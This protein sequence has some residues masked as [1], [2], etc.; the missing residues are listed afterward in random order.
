MNNT[1]PVILQKLCRQP[2]CAAQFI[3]AKVRLDFGISP[4]GRNTLVHLCPDCF[5][6]V[7]SKIQ[8]PIEKTDV[9]SISIDGDFFQFQ[10]FD[11]ATDDCLILDLQQ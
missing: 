8:P 7:M 1:A 5:N 4:A 10:V 6:R 2:T 9:F 3:P 11:I